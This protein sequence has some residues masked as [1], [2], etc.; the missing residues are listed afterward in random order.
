LGMLIDERFSMSQQCV[1]AAQKANCILGCIK[2]SVISRSSAV[3]LATDSALVRPH[4]EYYVQFWS[5]QYKRSM[6]LLEQVQRR[7]TK[8]IRG[9]EH[10]LYKDRLRELRLFRLA[11]RSQDTVSE[12]SFKCRNSGHRNKDKKLLAFRRPQVCRDLQKNTL[13]SPL[14]TLKQC[15]S[16]SLYAPELP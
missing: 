14:P 6:K 13:L 16:H 8:M 4:L 15:S 11:A 12:D 10:L 7:A 1:L 2:R 9:L 5:L 3:I